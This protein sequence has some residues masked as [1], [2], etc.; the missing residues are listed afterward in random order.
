MKLF[1]RLSEIASGQV[2]HKNA[3]NNVAIRELWDRSQKLEPAAAKP[4]QS[5]IVSATVAAEHLFYA[6]TRPPALNP[7]SF[8]VAQFRQ[9]YDAQLAMYLAALFQSNQLL[10][11]TLHRP[12]LSVV[13]DPATVQML[14]TRL[15]R[16]PQPDARPS[17]EVW[18]H[19]NNFANIGGPDFQSFTYYT[20]VAEM[21]TDEAVRSAQDN[22]A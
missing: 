21:T 16:N 10:A 19:L 7:R 17:G 3:T 15:L 2:A 4:I 18:A 20:A 22:A 9:F 6:E 14:L 8:T 5:F 11:K 12:L 13:N 1:R